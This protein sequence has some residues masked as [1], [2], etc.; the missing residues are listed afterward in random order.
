MRVTQFDDMSL[1]EDG[2]LNDAETLK[3]KINSDW[4]GF[5][6]STETHGAGVETPP[7]GGNPDDG[8][9]GRAAQ[10]AAKYHDNLYGKNKED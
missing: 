6:T 3:E 5:I 8:K 4:S 2:T 7:A 10:L 1:G 9:T